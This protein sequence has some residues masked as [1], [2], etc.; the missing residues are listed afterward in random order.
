LQELNDEQLAQVTG[1]FGVY[2]LY[3]QVF[4]QVSTGT[5]I[6]ANAYANGVNSGH[7]FTTASSITGPVGGG[8]LSLG[9]GFGSAIAR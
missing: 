6:Y 2:G 1:G 4:P 7:V 9:I 3:S 8:A 5:N